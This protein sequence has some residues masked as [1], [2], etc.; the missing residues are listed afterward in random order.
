MIAVALAVLLGFVWAA[1]HWGDLAA[2]RLPDTDDV[3]RLVEV[4]DWLA[5][6]GYADLHQYRLGPPGGTAM[7]WSRLADMPVAALILALAPLAGRHMAEV[8][9]V[10]LW[11]V[12]LF[13]AY[14]AAIGAV[15]RRL[16]VTGVTAMIVAAIAFPVTTLFVPGR[17]DHH[18][19]Q[20]VLLLAC[21]H[22][23]VAPPSRGRGI[24][25][26]AAMA[27]SAAIG[28]ET[29]PLL[30]VLGAWAVATWMRDDDARLQGI[31]IGLAIVGAVSFGLIP[32]SAP[33]G[34]CDALSAPLAAIL[35][36][37]GI[38]LGLIT[39]ASRHLAVPRWVLV[40]ACGIV[41]IGVAAAIA[42]AGCRVGPYGAVDAGLVR[43]WLHNVAEAQPLLRAAPADAIGYAGLAIVGLLAAL[44][45]ARLRGGAWWGVA[46]LIASGL[47]VACWQLR[48][49]Y[50]AAAI[51]PIALAALI[52]AA[53]SRGPIL[54]TGA[55]IASA[56][57]LYPLAGTALAQSPRGAVAP[58]DA[59]AATA[60]LAKLP[61]G[62]LAAPID[63]GP[64]I[65][66]D[67][68][69]ATLAGPY[70]RDGMGN[71]ALYRIM[72]GEPA[73]AARLLRANAVRYIVWCPGA[74]G[75]GAAPDSIAAR[76]AAPGFATI[77]Q[78]GGVRV[79]ARR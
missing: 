26:G 78:G 36:V 71:A 17:I 58:C 6:Q 11:P 4:R 52:D 56:G 22:G 32:A 1:R 21:V 7:H 53:R 76:G 19:L 61:P 2:L 23:M 46:A 57:I 72:L 48:G 42:P 65:L 67:T 73:V 66:R 69:H 28:F 62:R 8:V 29:V 9:A 63:L 37:T 30:A 41:L 38:M 35:V 31:A 54:L 5:G 79:L 15:A 33:S 70:H 10:C 25:I 16:G 64:A 60:L 45:Q 20:I 18:G 77:A 49:A 34:L 50:G 3:M 27:A 74:V 47:M 68:R 12:L 14:L 59:G 40:A 75:G 13:A 55:W 43:L 39:L 44:W 51:A 24:A